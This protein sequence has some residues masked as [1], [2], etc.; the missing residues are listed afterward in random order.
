MFYLNYHVSTQTCRLRVVPHNFL[1]FIST[2]MFPRSVLT[3]RHVHC[4]FAHLE[5]GCVHTFWLMKSSLCVTLNISHVVFSHNFP[6][7]YSKQST[8]SRL[9]Q[10]MNPSHYATFDLQ[11]H[12]RVQ[13]VT[14]EDVSVCNLSPHFSCFISTTTFPHK[15]VVYET[16]SCACSH[17]TRRVSAHF[18]DLRRY[19]YAWHLAYDTI[20]FT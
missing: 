4:M 17:T 13:I 16:R 9:F 7:V 11:G 1:C 14:Y 3:T 20:F 18:F 8:T 6:Q 12:L 10:L 15:Y 2:A 19:V 5:T